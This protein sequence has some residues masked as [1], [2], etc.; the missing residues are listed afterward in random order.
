MSR[1][2]PRLQPRVSEADAIHHDDDDGQ[3]LTTEGTTATTVSAG[4]RAT[5][6]FS[7]SG[8]DDAAVRALARSAIRR[9]SEH[10]DVTA[11]FH[12]FA[13]CAQLLGVRQTSDLVRLASLYFD[14]ACAVWSRTYLDRNSPHLNF[15]DFRRAAVQQFAD[16]GRTWRSRLAV[17]SA[18][19]AG[20]SIQGYISS[21][22]RSVLDA[23]ANSVVQLEVAAFVAGLADEDTRRFINTQRPQTLERAFELAADYEASTT[24]RGVARGRRGRRNGSEGRPRASDPGSAPWRKDTAGRAGRSA[25]CNRCGR[26]GH[27]RDACFA[28]KHADGSVLAGRNDVSAVEKEPAGNDQAW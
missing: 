23:E 2:S 1:R 3:D 26:P 28:V 14:G 10:D 24:S 22:R 7:S 12:T 4:S 17:V 15:A 6:S 8:D 9:L 21:F 5:P 11:W 16:P 19:Q 27:F 18:R 13:T 20:P 25:L